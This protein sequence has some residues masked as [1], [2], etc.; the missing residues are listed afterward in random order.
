MNIIELFA[1]AP[2]T[3]LTAFSLIVVGVEAFIR[4]SEPWSYTLSLAGLVVSGISALLA[5]DTT[6]SVFNGMVT[7]GGIG[8]FFCALFAV[9]AIFTIVLSRPYLRK[10][11]AEYGE[12]YLLV[13]FATIGMM[14]MATGG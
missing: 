3:I 13:L 10:E 2:I 4:K 14:L 11:H 7:A 5:L 9:A 6:G 12:Y 8:F 1:I